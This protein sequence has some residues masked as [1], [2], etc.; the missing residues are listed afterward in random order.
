MTADRSAPDLAGGSS[1]R[2]PE[3]RADL[4][5][6]MV[7]A[8]RTELPEL[9]GLVLQLAKRAGRLTGLIDAVTVAELDR[10]GRTKADYE[11]LSRLRSA[12][13]PYQLKP[14]ELASE[15]LLS[16]GGTTNVLHR[17]TAAG[18]LVRHADPA[19]RRS[20]WVRLTP[21]GVR[22]AE[23]VALAVNR[24]QAARLDRLP[25]DAARDL[26][27]QLREVLG[28]LDPGGAPALRRTGP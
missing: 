9:D 4:V 20:V 24:A 15:L 3:T 17:L 22:T 1:G 18:L 28:L 19:D 27:D 21:V 16:S 14:H 12:G 23:E 13:A 6:G 25:A 2:A 11:V 7:A 8:W 10:L 5:D 26:A